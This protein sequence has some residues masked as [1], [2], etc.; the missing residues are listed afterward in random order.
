VGSLSDS[1]RILVEPSEYSRLTNVGDMAMQHTTITRLAALWPSSDIRVFADDPANLPAY[2]PNVRGINTSGRAAWIAGCVP[3]LR[4]RLPLTYPLRAALASA[5]R[6]LVLRAPSFARKD[7][8]AFHEAVTESDALVVCG[9]GGVTDAF[10][11]FTAALLDVIAL[12]KANGGLVAMFGQGIGPLE[13]NTQLWSHAAAVL[14]HV[15]LIALREGRISAALLDAM[16]VPR[17]RVVVTG[18][19]AI[20]VALAAGA[21]GPRDALGVNVRIAHYADV[22]SELLPPLRDAVQAFARSRGAPL[23]A[24]PSDL[25]PQSGDG[26]PTEALLAGFGH[27]RPSRIDDPE[28][29]G[30][31]VSG[32]RVLLTGSYHA[33]VFA[34]AQGVPIVG[35]ERSAYYRDKWAGLLHQFGSG[36]HPVS[37]RASDWRDRLHEALTLAWDTADEVRDAL[38]AAAERQARESRAAYE[39]F[40]VLMNARVVQR[41]HA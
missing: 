30:R 8:A 5:E 16:N 2:A 28:S 17:D 36:V 32:C 31:A 21:H 15:D 34:L 12:A 33:G 27:V 14:P 39:R 26:Q 6:A 35:L 10:P 7:V 23:M 19:D 18:D 38:R 20:A 37:L 3:A 29:F 1:V 25:H 41:S 24:A 11:A 4:R 22:G 9:M 40:G 13:R